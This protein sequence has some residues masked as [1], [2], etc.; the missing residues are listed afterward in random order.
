M[1]NKIFLLIVVAIAISGCRVNSFTTA[2]ESVSFAPKPTSDSLWLITPVIHYADFTDAYDLLAVK[3]LKGLLKDKLVTQ[4]ML[5]TMHLTQPID[6]NHKELF[7]KS[8]Q[9]TSAEFWV[10]CSLGSEKNDPFE[11]FHQPKDYMKQQAVAY[12]R[13]FEIATG[14]EIYKQKVFTK[15]NKFDPDDEDRIIFM[16]SEGRL[17]YKALQKALK[18]L[19]KDMGK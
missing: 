17:H 14:K 7:L 3:E 6:L 15:L 11:T 19:K 4:E 9:A 8:L 13:I 5:R 18:N 12:I 16:A 10:V 1:K 2:Y